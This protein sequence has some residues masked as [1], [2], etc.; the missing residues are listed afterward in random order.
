MTN[1]ARWMVVLAVALLAVLP[2]LAKPR[3]GEKMVTAATNDYT[4]EVAVL[5]ITAPNSAQRSVN[6]A[7]MRHAEQAIA[8]F[9]KQSREY[10]APPRGGKNALHL[11][12]KAEYE[13]DRWLSVTCSGGM[14]FGGPHAGP[15][16]ESYLFDLKGGRELT[17][18]ELFRSGTPY[19]KIISDLSR[20]ELKTRDLGSDE[21]WQK[22]GTEPRTS[23]INT[24]TIDATTLTIIYP[25][26]Q[27][28]P[29]AA[30][31]QRIKIPFSRLR[32]IANPDGPVARVAPVLPE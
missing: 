27:V 10:G 1:L 29:Y 14:D 16:L 21:V 20:N 26:Y 19:L 2:A 3:L 15:L 13:T 8:S 32:S 23:I 24:F 25:A 17:L 31:P 12:M 28:A 30:G 9:R 22:R 4:V 6:A 18:K 11:T 5:Q 7:L